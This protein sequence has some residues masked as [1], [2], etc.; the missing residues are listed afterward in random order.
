M[1]ETPIKDAIQAMRNDTSGDIK[2][3]GMNMRS[4]LTYRDI[5]LSKYGRPAFDELFTMVKTPREL[6]LDSA[7]YG[8]NGSSVKN[9][10]FQSIKNEKLIKNIHDLAHNYTTTLQFSSN[11]DTSGFSNKVYADN[12]QLSLTPTLFWYDNTHLCLTSHYRDF[13]FD[14]KYRMVARGGFVEDKLSPAITKHVEKIG[15]TEG[16][17]RFGCYLLDDHS[18]YYFTGHLDGGSFMTDEEKAKLRPKC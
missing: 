12:H 11:G 4:N 1:R 8:P 5:F 2:Y 6:A 17:R 7:T 14:P 13:I 18:G 16:H 10:D 9:F 15:L 3:I